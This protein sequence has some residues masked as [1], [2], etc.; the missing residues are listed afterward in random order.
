MRVWVVL[1]MLV[2]LGVKGCVDDDCLSNLGRSLL[3]AE[4]E[5]EHFS[6][7]LVPLSIELQAHLN[8]TLSFLQRGK[9]ERAE[10]MFS[11]II[12]DSKS[13]V[14]VL[15]AYGQFL[16]SYLAEPAAALHQYIHSLHQ[17]PHLSVA[18]TG[19]ARMLPKTKERELQML[20]QYDQLRNQLVQLDFSTPGAIEVLE[21]VH[22][23]TNAFYIYHTNAIEGNSIAYAHVKH[24]L[25]TG[26]PPE[27]EEC[28]LHEVN[29]IRGSLEAL[30][31]TWN[32][33][34]QS[35][36]HSQGIEGDSRLAFCLTNP[37]ARSQL[38]LLPDSRNLSIQVPLKAQSFAI[39]ASESPLEGVEYPLQEE[40]FLLILLHIHSKVLGR[41]QPNIAG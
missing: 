30:Q 12:E 20:F 8:K 16:E 18:M 23:R 4:W 29:E 7:P 37:I 14:E 35:F 15:Q 41:T 34:I 28:S 36:D 11:R 26:N 27:G 6:K 9:R 3:I 2:G 38:S 22:S 40:D 33:A 39:E 5:R 17:Q 32:A 21:N 24:V 19:Y 13:H 10:K 1:A 25:E 31:F